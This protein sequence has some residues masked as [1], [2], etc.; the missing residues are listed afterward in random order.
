MKIRI[1][2]N[3]IRYRLT[4]SEV[5]QLAVTG[6][7]E[8][9]TIFPSNRFVYALEVNEGDNPLF[10][11]LGHNKITMHIPSSFCKDWAQNDIVGLSANMPFFEDNSLYL[12]VEKDFV[13]VDETIED[14]RDNFENPNKK[15]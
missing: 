15:L 12:L 10:A 1:K 13:C 5:N 8:E 4:K 6:Y 14:Q 2:G 3:S 7:L 11:R 9:Q